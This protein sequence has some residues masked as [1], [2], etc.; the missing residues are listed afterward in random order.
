V[1]MATG[2]GGNRRPFKRQLDG[3]ELDGPGCLR[4]TEARGTRRATADPGGPRPERGRVRWWRGRWRRWLSRTAR[5]VEAGYGGPYAH[6]RVRRFGGW[7]SSGAAVG[8]PGGRTT[9]VGATRTLGFLR[10][11]RSVQNAPPGRKGRFSAVARSIRTRDKD[12]GGGAGRIRGRSAKGATTNGRK[13][14]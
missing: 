10:A 2:E 14:W 5:A 4:I 6:G 8:A 3:H 12:G 7:R 13:G 1:E 9:A 11:R